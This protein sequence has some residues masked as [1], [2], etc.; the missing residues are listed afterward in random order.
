MDTPE[1][2]ESCCKNSFN[3]S[4][5]SPYVASSNVQDDT[6]ISTLSASSRT[7]ASTSSLSASSSTSTALNT[8]TSSSIAASTYSALSGSLTHAPT[9]SSDTT[10]KHATKHATT[11]GLGVGVPL[12]LLLLLSLGFLLYRELQRRS[13]IENLKREHQTTLS[14]VWQQQPRGRYPLVSDPAGIQELEGTHPAAGELDSQSGP[15][16][17]VAAKR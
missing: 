13:I 8:Q 3:F 7:G 6:S 10:F 5:G 11:I 16:Y 17:E 9:P 2:S 15:I 4:P 12:G 14:K 1:G